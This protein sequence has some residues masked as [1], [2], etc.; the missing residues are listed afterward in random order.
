MATSLSGLLTVVSCENFQNR[1]WMTSYYIHVNVRGQDGVSSFAYHTKSLRGSETMVFNGDVEVT[2]VLSGDLVVLTLFSTSLLSG[3]T[4]IG[5]ACLPL[6]DFREGEP[7][8]F[9]LLLG[10]LMFSPVDDLGSTLPCLLEESA[11]QVARSVEPSGCAIRLRVDIRECRFYEKH[12]VQEPPPSPFSPDFPDIQPFTPSGYEQG[13]PH[14]AAELPLPSS[15]SEST[16]TPSPQSKEEVCGA[17]SSS[18][19]KTPPPPLLATT[20]TAKLL[21]PNLR[22]SPKE[23]EKP[24][25][26][27]SPSTSLP[28]AP[29]LA[30]TANIHQV[31]TGTV[32]VVSDVLDDD[33]DFDDITDV[34]PEENPHSASGSSGY[35]TIE[36]GQ[37]TMTTVPPSSVLGVELERDKHN[38]DSSRGSSSGNPSRVDGKGLVRSTDASDREAFPRV[39]SEVELLPQPAPLLRN[40]ECR[41]S[42]STSTASTRVSSGGSASAGDVPRSDSSDIMEFSIPPPP[43]DLG[44]STKSTTLSSEWEQSMVSSR[45]ASPVVASVQPSQ[46]ASNKKDLSS[47]AKNASA[48]SSLSSSSTRS[49]GGH[50]SVSVEFDNGGLVQT[51]L[52]TSPPLSTGSPSFGTPQ[53]TSALIPR[54]K[55]P[56][57]PDTFMIRS[58]GTQKTPV[59]DE[60]HLCQSGMLDSTERSAGSLSTVASSHGPSGRSES[61]A[62]AFMREAKASAAA[63]EAEVSASDVG[64]GGA[65]ARIQEAGNDTNGLS[66]DTTGSLEVAVN[67]GSS[68][69]YREPSPCNVPRHATEE[70]RCER[71]PLSSRNSDQPCLH[72]A[73]ATEVNNVKEKTSNVAFDQ[74]APKQKD[75]TFTSGETGPTGPGTHHTAGT[76]TSALLARAR[77]TLAR[78]ESARQRKNDAAES[79]ASCIGRRTPRNST[80]LSALSPSTSPRKRNLPHPISIADEEGD[81]ILNPLLAQQDQSYSPGP[82]RPPR[83]LSHGLRSQRKLRSPKLQPTPQSA[84]SPRSSRESVNPSRSKSDLLSLARMYANKK[85][86]RASPRQSPRPDAENGRDSATVSLGA[87]DSIR[88]RVLKDEN[89]MRDLGMDPNARSLQKD[90]NVLERA[91]SLLKLANSARNSPSVSEL[92]GASMSPDSTL[93]KQ[94]ATLSRARLLLKSRQHSRSGAEAQLLVSSDV[95]SSNSSTRRGASIPRTSDPVAHARLLLRNRKNSQKRTVTLRPRLVSSPGVSPDVLHTEVEVS[96][97]EPDGS[98]IF[99][100][101]STIEVE[102]DRV[103]WDSLAWHPTKAAT[104]IC[105]S[106]GQDP[107]L[108]SVHIVSVPLIPIC[109]RTHQRTRT[110]AAGGSANADGGVSEPPAAVEEP[111]KRYLLSRAWTCNVVLPVSEGSDPPPLAPVVGLLRPAVEKVPPAVGEE[112]DAEAWHRMRLQAEAS[113]R[114]VG[115]LA[116]PLRG[117]AT[118]DIELGSDAP[119]DEPVVLPSGLKPQLFTVSRCGLVVAWVEGGFVTVR[120]FQPSQSSLPQNGGKREQ[121]PKLTVRMRSG[122]DPEGDHGCSDLHWAVGDVTCLAVEENTVAIGLRSGLMSLYDI[123][124]ISSSAGEAPPPLIRRVCVPLRGKVSHVT[125]TGCESTFVAA[126]SA[127]HVYFAQ[128]PNGLV[129]RTTTSEESARTTT[130]AEPPSQRLRCPSE[131]TAIA[132]VTPHSA[133]SGPKDVVWVVIGTAAGC[134][135]VKRWDWRANVTSPWCKCFTNRHIRCLAT[136][137]CGKMLL[138]SLHNDSDILLW[139]FGHGTKQSPPCGSPDADVSPAGP[140]RAAAVM[141][142]SPRRT[143]QPVSEGS[144]FSGASSVRSMTTV[145][146]VAR[147]GES[148]MEPVYITPSD[149]ARAAT[150]LV[151]AKQMERLQWWRNNDEPLAR[152]ESLYDAALL[153]CEWH[154]PEENDHAS[155]DDVSVATSRIRLAAGESDHT[156]WLLEDAY[157]RPCSPHPSTKSVC[158]SPGSQTVLSPREPGEETDWWSDLRPRIVVYDSAASCSSSETG[159]D[160]GLNAHRLPIVG[161]WPDWDIPWKDE[162]YADVLSRGELQAELYYGEDGVGLVPVALTNDDDMGLDPQM[163]FAPADKL[164]VPHEWLVHRERTC[165]R[166]RGKIA[167]T[168]TDAEHCADIPL[169]KIIRSLQL[170]RYV[171][172][173]DP[174]QNGCGVECTEEISFSTEPATPSPT[175]KYNDPSSQKH[176]HHHCH[177]HRRHHPHHSHHCHGRHHEENVLSRP[178]LTLPPLYCT[179]HNTRLKAQNEL[180][181]DRQRSPVIRLLDKSEDFLAESPTSQA[182]T[183][184]DTIRP[185]LLATSAGLDS[186]GPHSTTENS[187]DESGLIYSPASSSEAPQFLSRTDGLPKYQLSPRHDGKRWAWDSPDFP[188]DDLMHRQLVIPPKFSLGRDEWTSEDEEGAVC[189]SGGESPSTR[190]AAGLSRAPD[191]TE[192]PGEEKEAAGE[193][194]ER[195][196]ESKEGVVD[197]PLE[198]GAVFFLTGEGSRCSTPPSSPPAAQSSSSNDSVASGQPP[199]GST[200]VPSSLSPPQ[201]GVIAASY[202]LAPEMHRSPLPQPSDAPA[203]SSANLRSPSIPTHPSQRKATPIRARQLRRYRSTPLQPSPR[204]ASEGPQSGRGSARSS[205]GS[206][207]SSDGCDGDSPRPTAETSPPSATSQNA[208][209]ASTALAA[210]SGTTR[211]A[212]RKRST[213]VVANFALDTL[214]HDDEDAL[215]LAEQSR[216]RTQTEKKKKIR[217]GRRRS[218]GL[219]FASES[220]VGAGIDIDVDSFDEA[221]LPSRPRR[222]RSPASLRALRRSRTVS[223]AQSGDVVSPTPGKSVLSGKE[224]Q[225]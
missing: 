125:I 27:L 139:D 149:A 130:T 199:A 54:L 10:P 110:D 170:F 168:H 48:P 156:P 217:E 80:R 74:T 19:E 64:E 65:E 16:A 179:H 20:V 189:S 112:T 107:S 86:A 30:A 174:C 59:F 224:F 68:N 104:I 55:L 60:A 90:T 81:S 207:R 18:E 205:L 175:P 82:T 146:S 166:C 11:V 211:R 99:S 132:L 142:W 91:R 151:T 143:R 164:C 31:M 148:D 95:V 135:E 52:V 182:G 67:T 2:G 184:P 167:L 46:L 181:L 45:S 94:E 185:V 119:E 222:L 129:G 113:A 120:S 195:T 155:F 12:V 173:H 128:I 215:T 158:L 35:P 4:F 204:P 89:G 136:S 102:G 157:L 188:V 53:S 161:D 193:A 13:T 176:R 111:R 141:R 63:A 78:R 93:S 50:S 79:V 209:A 131:V 138:C 159:S 180:E 145:T 26:P 58:M 192:A 36:G 21:P 44:R 105:A 101:F 76:S 177:H 72:E 22:R 23:R 187:G 122:S 32:D 213:T 163:Y 28:L 42:S 41:N 9:R 3:D 5:Q 73:S 62:E 210:H 126:G 206:A 15:M 169:R 124:S 203:R 152:K 117:V 88:R 133:A 219:R 43:G 100:S 1:S 109:Q 190:S 66:H 71:S 165:S 118:F 51:V 38:S 116:S 123:S 40:L 96:P 218:E 223:S 162:C 57:T 115:V 153:K 147:E 47:L 39:D 140:N 97:E 106:A 201:Q 37:H 194:V 83:S 34:Y 61:Y 137:P 154:V 160:R 103:P 7:E 84:H 134:L 178:V 70:G 214:N 144:L 225:V 114:A 69:Q 186:S 108:D 17:D 75:R 121:Q 191:G 216:V 183:I 8:E 127:T 92:R 198:P 14:L 77:E 56:I 172:P 150:G 87:K 25:E 171:D 49:T 85:S 98:H 220:Q 221:D 196:T 29:R 212:L 33:T 197:V 208:K 202:G 6:K 24:E 200:T